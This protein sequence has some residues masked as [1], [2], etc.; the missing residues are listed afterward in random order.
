MSFSYIT[1]IRSEDVSK[2]VSHGNHQSQSERQQEAHDL[3]L[4]GVNY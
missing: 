2:L 3:S 1:W 4:P